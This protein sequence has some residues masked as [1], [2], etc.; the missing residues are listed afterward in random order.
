METIQIIPGNAINKEKWDLL[1]L[2]QQQLL[3][4]SVFASYTY[5]NAIAGTWYGLVVGDYASVM[6]LIFKKKG[7]I[8]YLS[9][10]AFGRQLGLI[11]ME[12]VQLHDI[13][14]KAL[15]LCKYGDLV[16]NDSNEAV[17]PADCG[18]WH[19]K[20]KGR[21]IQR[22]NL[23]LQL[24]VGYEQLWSGYAVVLRRKIRKAR[25]ANL[26]FVMPGI[27]KEHENGILDRQ[28]LVHKLIA[29][30]KIFLA[31]KMG[32]AYNLGPALEALERLLLS[33]FGHKYF[34]PCAVVDAAGAI[35]MMDVYAIDH[36]RV[37]KM[38]SVLVDRGREMNAMAF[39]VDAFLQLYGG[40]PL[41]FDFMGSSIPAVRAWVEDFGAKECP[42]FIYRYNALPWPLNLLK[43]I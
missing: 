22:P 43:T 34:Y 13:I 28:T 12:V 20:G 40:R 41:L 10:L 6:P 1:A 21:L 19:H 3:P 33:D 42:Y 7:G 5:L 17:L 4:G 36:Q 9:S 27:T 29:A 30:N 8:P 31:E 23:V 11:G 35:Q 2:G 25:K 37:Y 24:I 38:L 16:F 26:S 39:G 15:S 32:K 14:D 18:R